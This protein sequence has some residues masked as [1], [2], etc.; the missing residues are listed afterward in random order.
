MYVQMSFEWDPEK[1]RLNLVKHGI[2]FEFAQRVWDDPHHQILDDRVVDGERR[3]HAVGLI[4]IVAIIV[5]V[6]C[7]PDEDD[8]EHVRI[9]SARA[10]SARERR[11]YEQ[12]AV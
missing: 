4:G 12:Q 2:S 7:H 10:A 1:A 5:V 8:L 3:Y 11:R 6:H 9:I